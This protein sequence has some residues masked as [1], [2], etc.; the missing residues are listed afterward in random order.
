MDL[1]YIGA[2]I[3]TGIV[4]GII[5][6]LVTR[7]SANKKIT[8]Y[9]N[10]AT[11]I[12]ETSEKL[13]AVQSELEIAQQQFDHINHETTE[14]QELKANSDQLQ[15][16][17]D[18]N[19]ELLDK[20]TAELDEKETA[21]ESLD[22]KLHGLMAKLDLYSRI[23]EFVEQGMFEIPA[24]LHETTSQFA[25]EEIK[26]LR[27]RQKEMIK[28]QT[29]IPFPED[30]EISGNSSHDKKI[31]AGQIKLMLTAFN[32]E[33]DFLIAKVS[34]GNFPRILEQIENKAAAL[35]KSAATLHC[36]FNLE[37]V[38]LKYNECKL[39]YQFKLK[40]QEEQEEQKRI[41][42]QIREEQRAIK[43]Y[44]QAVAKAEKEERMYREMLEKARKELE[45]V[46]EAERIEAQARI[47]L[48]EQQLAEAEENGKRA[49]SMAEQTRRGHVYIISN[50]GSFGE[51]VYKIGLTR[52]LEPMDRVKELGDAS[53]PFP[54]DVH[55]I[56][57]A[58][59]APNLETSLHHRFTRN[60]V[61][62]VNLRKEF[63]R[64]PLENIRNA[65]DE[66]TEGKADFTMTALADEYYESRRLQ[67]RDKAVA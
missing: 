32:I 9:K 23:D 41:R 58:E 21:L 60:R 24:Y 13:S 19:S 37:Y 10:L 50:I 17:L 39:Q 12:R 25:A 14:L 56:I 59:D 28:N 55:A 4:T 61:N 48:L 6:I 30:I 54:F 8:K 46:S 3:A 5:A 1:Y 42:E 43:E 38:K 40:K 35:E 57:Y 22:E 62:A 36:G 20:V 2:I 49:K 31:L 29:A 64:V 65:V 47:A 27:E 51:G 63:F 67:G 33:C 7:S 16:T 26:R 11:A 44:E 53:V 15:V 18:T 45:R 52:R 34:P 66:L